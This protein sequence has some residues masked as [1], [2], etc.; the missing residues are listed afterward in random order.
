MFFSYLSTPITQKSNNNNS[1]R[2]PSERQRGCNI[3]EG[4]F[5]EYL[6]F[7]SCFTPKRDLFRTLNKW[8]FVPKPNQTINTRHVNRRTSAPGFDSSFVALLTAA[9]GNPTVPFFSSHFQDNKQQQMS[10]LTVGGHRSKLKEINMFS[11]HHMTL[12]NTLNYKIYNFEGKTHFQPKI[13]DP[14]EL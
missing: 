6:T 1:L 13:K 5:A 8:F 12:L 14:A 2:R 3:C 7:S 9:W 11:L 10:S 4:D